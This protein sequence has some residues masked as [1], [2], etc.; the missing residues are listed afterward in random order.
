MSKFYEALEQAER[1]RTLRQGPTGTGLPPNPSATDEP[2]PSTA[3]DSTASPRRSAVPDT[4]EEIWRSPEAGGDLDE[5]LISLV[6]PASFAAEQYLALRYAVEQVPK[7]DG[8]VIVAVSGATVRD[9]KTTTSINLAGALGQASEARVLLVDADLRRPSVAGYLGMN[10]GHRAGLVELITDARRALGEVVVRRAEFNLSVLP[11]G[12][13]QRV[14]YELLQSA[15]LGE[16]L[17]EAR[18]QFDY[19]VVDTPPALPAPDCRVLSRWVD[20]WLLVV[21]AHKTPRRL[22]E[23]AIATVEPEK[24]IG[25]V[26]NGDDQA[27]TRYYASHAGDAT[28]PRSTR[29]WRWARGPVRATPGLGG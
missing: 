3:H 29:R 17:D 25:I 23:E 21:A 10:H 5:H 11:A 24:L 19:L 2:M 12:H 26:F 28:G 9:G 16:V 20:A 22:V 6:A 7:R 1:E 13:P 15:R 27:R 14:P 8:C 4:S 18:R